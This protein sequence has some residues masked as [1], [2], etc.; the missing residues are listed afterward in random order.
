MA[1]KWDRFS[2]VKFGAAGY[3]VPD[4]QYMITFL[5]Q[6]D[7]RITITMSRDIAEQAVSSLSASLERHRSD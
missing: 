4:D 2:A 6:N 1:G 7:D 3:D 5:A